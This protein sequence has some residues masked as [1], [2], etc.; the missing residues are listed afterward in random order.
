MT[1]SRLPQGTEPFADDLITALKR[2]AWTR[3][4]ST[5]D[6]AEAAV[7]AWLADEGVIQQSSGP[8]PPTAPASQPRID[9]AARYLRDLAERLLEYPTDHYK[10]AYEA[11]MAE[12]AEAEAQAPPQ[13][14]APSSSALVEVER[15]QGLVK[16]LMK[17]EPPLRQAVERE[18]LTSELVFAALNAAHILARL[19]QGKAE[20]QQMR[21]SEVEHWVTRYN[22]LEAWRVSTA[23]RAAALEGQLTEAQQSLAQQRIVIERQSLICLDVGTRIE[24]IENRYEQELATLRATAV[25]VSVMPDVGDGPCFRCGGNNPVIWFATPNQRWNE[26]V[27]GP[28]AADD[29]GGLLCPNCF[30]SLAHAAGHD[31]CWAFIPEDERELAW[32]ERWEHGRTVGRQ[33]SEAEVSTLSRR[34]QE[35]ESALKGLTV[36]WEEYQTTSLDCVA[37]VRAV[38][39]SPASGD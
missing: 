13:T 7:R 18:R 17:F 35:L 22:E 19:E 2:A 10:E 21:V 20:E 15:I 23:Q 39:A 1:L 37:D 33:E 8:A 30:F 9:T 16:V 3:K 4:R 31:R 32:G 6:A 34:V 11:L 14:A 38:L 25:P 26:V 5:T 36:K 27:G 28:D 12:A 29:P 24:S